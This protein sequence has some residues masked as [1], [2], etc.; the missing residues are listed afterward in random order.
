MILNMYKPKGWT[1]FDVVKKVRSIT[2]EKKVGHGGT[3]DPFAE[4]V[5]VLGT[6]SDTKKLGMIS[7]SNKEYVA[8]L[9]LGSRTDTH[10]IE[11]HVVED[12]A[13]P[14]LTLEE[15]E[16]VLKSFIGEQYQTPPMYS[17]KKV[18]GQRLYKLARKNIEIER[19]PCL[20]KIVDIELIYFNSPVIEF[21]VTCSKGTYI[22]VLGTDIANQLGT[23]GHLIALKRKKV[24]EYAIDETIQIDD[25]VSNGCI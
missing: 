9:K 11:G 21:S 14:T 25:L 5:L 13:I 22:R 16:T 7:D 23:V 1:S 3:L 8:T 20:I 24:G 17:A 2:K 10:D 18:N 6:G 15:V 4:G 19:E 12:K